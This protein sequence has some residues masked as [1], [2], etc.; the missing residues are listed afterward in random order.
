MVISCGAPETDPDALRGPDGTP[1]YRDG[2]YA[3]SFSHTNPDGWRSFVSVRVRAGLVQE[4]CFDAVDSDAG[5]LLADERYLEQYRL[6]TG[7]DLARTLDALT[8]QLL[9]RQVLPPTATAGVIGLPSAEWTYEFVVLVRAALRSARFGVTMDA[10][11]IERLPSWGPYVAT[12]APDELGWRAELVLVYDSDGAVAAGYR[13]IRTELD[14]SV[15]VKSQDAVYQALF[16]E[17]TGRTSDAVIAG[18]IGRLLGAPDADDVD[19]VSGAT[20][21][22]T[23]FDALVARV[24]RR[25]MEAPL[26]GRLCR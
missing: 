18:L 24:E 25:R 6:D 22:A 16:E 8:A 15:R 3:A 11:G 7:V 12:D 10:A 1:L 23:R 13:E 26:P 5:R 21:T 4:V 14:G 9:D 17:A 20:L 2:R 19:A